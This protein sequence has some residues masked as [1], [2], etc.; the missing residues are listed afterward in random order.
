MTAGRLQR[1]IGSRAAGGA[2]L[3]VAEMTDVDRLTASSGVPVLTLMENAGR[4]VANEIAK[5]WSARA[6]TVLCGPGNNGGDGYVVARHLQARGFPTEVVTI[7]DH[8]SLKA[9]AAAMAKAWTGPTHA[10]DPKAPVRG[11]LYVDAIFGAGLSRGLSPELAQLFE[12]IAV[13]DIPIVVI[14]VPSGICG[15][16]ARFL[17]EVQP[18]TAALTV[19]FFRKKPAH[20]L[21]P[22]RGH[23]GE[24]VCADI[25]IPSGMLHALAQ[26]RGPAVAA[27]PTCV[28]NIAPPL[29][30]APKATGHKY[31]R[32]HC[33]VVAGPAHATGAT[34]L[35]ARGAL[36]V[37]AGLV[38]VVG[39]ASA[40]SAL[41]PALTAIMV[42]SRRRAA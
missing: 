15:D 12:D 37:G 7:G 19:T 3:V 40:V 29:P 2:A 4:Q 10:F 1:L 5:R 17:D 38:T 14:D 35:A 33:V 24:I 6:T 28:E 25:G 8:K 13:A 11:D 18:W 30:A 34:R 23:C 42:H 39:D 26:T 20:V 36:R 16:R 27:P 31:S 21:Y 41:A 22:A 9:D 32:G